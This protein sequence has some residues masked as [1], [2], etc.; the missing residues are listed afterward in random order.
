MYAPVPREPELR[1]CISEC[2]DSGGSG[3]RVGTTIEPVALEREAGRG[4]DLAAAAED[5]VLEDG[6][7]RALDA[8]VYERSGTRIS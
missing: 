8:K 1:G 6:L 2:A 5:D 4:R 7:A 3:L